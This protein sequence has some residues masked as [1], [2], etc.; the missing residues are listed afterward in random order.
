MKEC[1]YWWWWRQ[2]RWLLM[3]M[4][5]RW[6]VCASAMSTKLHPITLIYGMS[7]DKPTYPT[8]SLSH[9]CRIFFETISISL[10]IHIPQSIFAILSMRWN[11]HLLHSN[12]VAWSMFRTRVNM[13]T[14]PKWVISL[15]VTVSIFTFFEENHTKTKCVFSSL[16]YKSWIY[17]N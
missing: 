13:R 1:W 11:I 8:D 16:T 3:M 4:M 14:S 2:R 6:D 12:A 5:M 17:V 10:A 7:V 15:T 9:F